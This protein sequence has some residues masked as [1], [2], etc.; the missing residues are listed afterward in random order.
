MSCDI[1]ASSE[2]TMKVNQCSK[3]AIDGT[4]KA[5]NARKMG[6]EKTLVLLKNAQFK[7]VRDVNAETHNHAPVGYF[8]SPCSVKRISGPG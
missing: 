3:N 2:E 7:G 4:R 1:R 8:P 6:R 5:T